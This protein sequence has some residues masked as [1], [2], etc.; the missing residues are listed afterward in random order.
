M[1]VCQKTYSLQKAAKQLH[2][3]FTVP[4]SRLLDNL[5]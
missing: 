3:S 4:L 2:H 1:E 5:S